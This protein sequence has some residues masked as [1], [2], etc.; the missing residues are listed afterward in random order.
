MNYDQIVKAVTYGDKVVNGE[1]FKKVYLDGFC[2]MVND[3]GVK[4]MLCPL[5]FKKCFIG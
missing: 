4:S 3:C 5:D 2:L 1:L